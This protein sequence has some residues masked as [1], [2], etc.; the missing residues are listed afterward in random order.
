M[1]Q[2]PNSTELAA[3][4]GIDPRAQRLAEIAAECPIGTGLVSEAEISDFAAALTA[5]FYREREADFAVK[6]RAVAQAEAPTPRQRRPRKPNIR[7]LIEQ[8]KAAGATSVTLPDGTRL[9]LGRPGTSNAN[10]WDEVLIDAAD[11]KRPS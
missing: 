10:P 5:E 8:A 3:S 9:E 7:T 11:T 6:A 4:L 2:S 1:T